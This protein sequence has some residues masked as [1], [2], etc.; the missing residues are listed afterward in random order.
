M[1]TA[2]G[3]VNPYA[4]TASS[5]TDSEV[6][7]ISSARS[8]IYVETADSGTAYPGGNRQAPDG[9]VHLY[10]TEVDFTGDES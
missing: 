8:D 2:L 9:S 6:T 4:T 3:S 1:G 5:L 10:H 7:E